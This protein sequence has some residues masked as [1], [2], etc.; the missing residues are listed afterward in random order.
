MKSAD[1]EFSNSHTTERRDL[2]EFLAVG[3]AT[4]AATTAAGMIVSAN[5]PTDL[6][7][8]SAELLAFAIQ[9]IVFLAA[10]FSLRVAARSSRSWD[11][12]RRLLDNRWVFEGT[13]LE[14]YYS[15]EE[16][17]NGHRVPHLQRTPRYAVFHVSY[18]GPK[19]D[20]YWIVGTLY[21]PNGLV[22]SEWRTGSLIFNMNDRRL[23]YM[24]TAERF[25]TRGRIRG[26]GC[27]QFRQRSPESAL[28]TK[29]STRQV[30]KW[31]SDIGAGNG[32]IL[33]DAPSV[34]R[35]G[36]AG[37]SGTR[38]SFEFLRITHEEIAHLVPEATEMHAEIIIP[39]FVRR[40]HE[41]FADRLENG[42]VDPMAAA[43][44]PERAEPELR[45]VVSQ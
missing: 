4:F 45:L 2:F 16:V 32:Y 10:L 24:Y 9:S 6:P 18:L 35:N 7:K 31:G 11:W 28:A 39:T 3:F 20:R 13:W 21:Y 15:D 22:H 8:G 37:T 41:R 43:Y 36:D 25:A 38:S 34:M 44:E 29:G 5:A 33:E 14:V 17:K 30:N 27:L 26:L 1:R 42:I 40:Y 12:L 19:E 23:E